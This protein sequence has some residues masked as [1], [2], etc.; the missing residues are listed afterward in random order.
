M[1]AHNDLDR[2]LGAWFSGEATATPPPEPLA[3][4]IESTR[5][6]RPRPALVARIG[7]DWVAAGTTSGVRGGIAGLRPA[8]AVVVVGLLALALAGGAVLVGSRL[9]APRPIPHSYLNE[10]VSAQDLSMP[11]AYPAL[12]PLLDGRILVIG[13]DGDGGGTGTRALVYDPATGVSEQTG[14]LVSGDSLEVESAVRL[15]DGKLLIVG[16]AFAQ[17]FDPSTL[18]FTPVGPM[19]TPRTWAAVA[20]LPDGHVLIAG[21]YPSGQDGATSSAEL[22]D[23]DTSTFSTTGSLGTSHAGAAAAIL[24]DGRV[25][26]APGLSRLTAEVYDPGTGTFSAA[27]TISSYSSGDI[28]IALP[29]GRVVVFDGSV[30]IKG[31]AEVWDPT[32]LTFSPRHELPGRVRSATLLDDGRILVVGGEPANWSGIFYPTAGVTTPVQTTRAWGPRATR[33]ADGRV[34]IVGGLTDGNIRSE[35]GGTSAPGV[36]TVEIFQ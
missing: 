1:T 23:P 22:F 4:T 12:V 9:I 25:F 21:G 24:P 32:S 27:G 31:F 2:T 11:M 3:R 5:N 17:V 35:G 20:V 14:P 10:L 6:T 8:V 30:G 16:N 36:S 29:D 15:K 33:L 26:V 19:I 18:R 13:N 28:A 34:L 7:S